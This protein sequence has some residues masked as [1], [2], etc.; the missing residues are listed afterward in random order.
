MA[1][2]TNLFPDF[3]LLGLRVEF[4][5]NKVNKLFELIKVQVASIWGTL[6]EK[7]LQNLQFNTFLII[8]PMVYYLEILTEEDEL[9]QIHY[10]IL[11]LDLIEGDVPPQIDL[12]LAVVL[13]DIKKILINQ[14]LIDFL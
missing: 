3:S 1:V 7:S 4:D 9:C 5:R 2:I 6:F 10:H 12:L 14:F 8:F 13:E 11:F